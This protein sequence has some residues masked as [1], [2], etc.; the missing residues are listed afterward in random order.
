MFYNVWD[1]VQKSYLSPSN[2]VENKKSNSVFFRV[3]SIFQ[4]RAEEEIIENEKLY[5]PGKIVVSGGTGFVGQEVSRLLRKSGYEV[6]I[7]SRSSGQYRMTWDNLSS[8]GLPEGTK[9]VVNLAGQNV[10][11]PLR[12][13]SPEFNELCRTSRIQST[14][15]LAT[16]IREA[17]AQSK[18][19]VFVSVSGVGYYAPHP[20]LEY[21]E[22]GAKG[23]DWLADMA[24]EW[25]QAAQ[26]CGQDVRSVILRPGVVLGRNGGMIQQIFAPFF[27]GVGGCMG[28]GGQPIPW[29]HVK[30]L[31]GLIKHAVENE[32]MEGVYNAVAPQLITNQQFVN[33]FAGA[34]GR[35]AFF[36]LPEFVWNFVFGEE[37]A[38][39]ITKG[40]WVVPKRTLDSGFKFRFPTIE[41]AAKEFSPFPYVDTD[42]Q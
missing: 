36:P 12:R 18:P 38:A 22:G 11:D 20:T 4:L 40:Q 28:D 6:I 27:F 25:E 35:P 41:E 21:D 31:S 32:K 1:T 10:L 19:S 23:V 9:A 29:I 16:A 13:W 34:L 39:M 24:G 17:P 26:D 5:R 42:I 14:K 33:A 7:L 30:D 2:Y 37:R 15:T 3:F 8:A